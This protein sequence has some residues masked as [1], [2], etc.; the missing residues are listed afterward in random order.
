MKKL[1][2]ITLVLLLLASCT[3]TD[4]KIKQDMR[5]DLRGY[6]MLHTAVYKDGYHIQ[7][8]I[9]KLN[10]ETPKD[11]KCIMIKRAEQYIQLMKT[12]D[13]DCE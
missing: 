9:V 13:E 3:T 12:F 5:G 7:R 8:W 10:D 1:F 6:T 2:F 4:Y 11:I